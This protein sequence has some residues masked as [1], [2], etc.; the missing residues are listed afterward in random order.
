MA[1]LGWTKR[2][3]REF[4]WEHSRIPAEHLGRAGGYAWIEI[5]AN[6]VTCGSAALDPWP[7]TAAPENFVLIVADGGH[8]TNSY[9][10]QGYS[11]SVVGRE[12]RL[13]EHFLRLLDAAER[14]LNGG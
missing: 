5:D 8:P 6:A 14:D 10:L 1:G 11:P 13:P 12:I 3:M 9:W 2:S 7:I 4:L